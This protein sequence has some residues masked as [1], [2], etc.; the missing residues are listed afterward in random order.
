MIYSKFLDKL[1]QGLVYK[2]SIQKRNKILK[3]V[4]MTAFLKTTDKNPAYS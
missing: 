2:V 4:D 1:T 3:N